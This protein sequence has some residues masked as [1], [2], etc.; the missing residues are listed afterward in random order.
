MNEMAINVSTLRGAEVQSVASNLSN[1][2][3][4]ESDVHLS[5]CITSYSSGSQELGTD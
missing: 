3:R 5:S 1:W 4:H 2:L